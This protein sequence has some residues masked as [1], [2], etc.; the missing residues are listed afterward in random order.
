MSQIDELQARIMEALDRIGRG[1]EMRAA[2][3]GP[4][5][6]ERICSGHGSA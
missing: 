5:A 3:E 1:V 6:D 4:G 2:A